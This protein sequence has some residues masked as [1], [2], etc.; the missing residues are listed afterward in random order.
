MPKRPRSHQIEDESRRAF[1]S[2]LP[3]PW[4]FR[5]ETRDY[6]IDGRVEIF[7]DRN[8]GTGRMFLVQLKATDQVELGRA[9]TVKIKKEQHEYYRQLD[10]PV[11]IVRYHVPTKKIFIK[12]H[13]TFDAYYS[14]KGAKS[15]SIKLSQSDEWDEQTPYSIVSDLDAIRI[16]KSPQ[17]PLPFPCSLRVKGSSVHGVI[18]SHMDLLIRQAASRL[19]NAVLLTGTSPL[20][21]IV[22]GEQEA[23]V[24]LADGKGFTYH[25]SKGYPQDIAKNKFPFDVMISIALALSIAGH[26]G[27]AAQL[28]AEYAHESHII[29][30]PEIT[31]RLSRC[32]AKAQ[33]VIEALRL[34][35]NLMNDAQARQFAD[36]FFLTAFSKAGSMSTSESEY[37]KEYL[38]RRIEL[39]EIKGSQIELAV[40]HYNLG[41]HLRRSNRWQALGQY[42]KASKYDPNYLKRSYFLTELAGI[43][44]LNGRYGLASKYYDTA[45]QLGGDCI[46]LH[47]DALMFSG[48]YKRSEELFESFLQSN[49]DGNS[50]WYLKLVALKFIRTTLKIDEQH[51][52]VEAAINLFDNCE[53]FSENQMS[54]AITTALQ[55]DALC[56]L[57]WFNQGVL[58]HKSNST[59]KNDVLQPFL[60]EA[61]VNNW[62][63]ESWCNAMML[64]FSSQTLTLFT[65]ILE[66]A[67]RFNGSKLI[68]QI[69]KFSESQSSAFPADQF[70]QLVVQHLRDLP[71][72][73]PTVVARLLRSETDYEVINLNTNEEPP[74]IDRKSDETA[75]A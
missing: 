59:D 65:Q 68:E 35:E 26:N 70:V 48:S 60:I 39:A 15:L 72:D 12:W 49:P 5:D 66:T 74:A 16:V 45:I 22:V 11:L 6:G 4:L 10:M 61:L 50:E 55:L 40:A 1:S 43:L 46:A 20:L 27:I 32:L 37:F 19:P 75:Q 25:T 62:D 53:S 52:K 71:E 47:A 41:N 69:V 51:R 17:I 23:S 29:S 30:H 38:K 3:S 57:A 9:L 2:K 14:K 8:L 63:V 34:S 24:T 31:V 44:F 67:Y 54:A 28:I 33:R 7:D 13:H 21:S 18:A 56:G 58:A 42:K 73:K 64:S 36:L